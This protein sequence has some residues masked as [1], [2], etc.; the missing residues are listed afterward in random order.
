MNTVPLDKKNLDKMIQSRMKMN[1]LFQK[2]KDFDVLSDEEVTDGIEAIK[3]FY[4]GN[5]DVLEE[6]EK[7]PQ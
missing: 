5:I 7:T 4:R 3:E 2:D 6:A 1:T